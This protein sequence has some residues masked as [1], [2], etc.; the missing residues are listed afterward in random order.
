MT[1]IKVDVSV[2]MW[3]YNEFESNVE[4]DH[5]AERFTV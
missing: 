5:C 3:E 1:C 2:I 4:I